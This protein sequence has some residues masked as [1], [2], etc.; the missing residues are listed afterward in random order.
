MQLISVKLNSCNKNGNVQT[1]KLLEM[2]SLY[3]VSS[4]YNENDLLE[5]FLNLFQGSEA[6]FG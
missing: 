6:N 4:K 5:M 1:R 2:G 3:I